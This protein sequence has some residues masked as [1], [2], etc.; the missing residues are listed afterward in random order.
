MVKGL[1]EGFY[2]GSPW[3]SLA[4]DCRTGAILALP[5]DPG[6]LCNGAGPAP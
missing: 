4:D 3:N 6:L 1:I 2:L 5:A